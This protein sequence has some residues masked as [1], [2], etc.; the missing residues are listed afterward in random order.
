MIVWCMKLKPKLVYEDFSKDKEIFDFNYS[1]K[2]KY[3]DDS[4]KLVVAKMRNETAGA[5]IEEFVGL[6]PKIYSFSTDDN[7]EHKKVKGVNKNVGKRINHKEN[8]DA[9]LNK[10][11]L[12]HL[13]NRIQ[14]KNH[15]IGTYKIIKISLSCFDDKIHIPNNGHDGL[16]LG[17]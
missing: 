5:G 13:M 10:K 8:K 4:N 2:S 16:A 14:I 17:Y 9:L 7:S 15:R 12:R 1:T 3:Y 6:K 11:W